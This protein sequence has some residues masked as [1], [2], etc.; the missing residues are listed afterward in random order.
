MQGGLVHDG[1]KSAARRILILRIRR[2]VWR[3]ADRDEPLNGPVES[4]VFLFFVASL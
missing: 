2:R 1:I 3:L 4:F